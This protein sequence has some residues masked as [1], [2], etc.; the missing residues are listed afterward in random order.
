MV[1]VI[2]TKKASIPHIRLSA[3]IIL[4]WYSFSNSI[5]LFIFQICPLYYAKQAVYVFKNISKSFSIFKV[6]I[7][8]LY[9]MKHKKTIAAQKIYF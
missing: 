1:F 9:H 8:I 7:Y 4:S 2:K 3:N 5:I 6:I